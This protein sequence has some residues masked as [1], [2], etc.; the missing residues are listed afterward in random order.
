MEG[1]KG[2]GCGGGVLQRNFYGRKYE[3]RIYQFI[4]MNYWFFEDVFEEVIRNLYIN[5]FFD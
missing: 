1:I 5:I 2:W 3:V 4:V